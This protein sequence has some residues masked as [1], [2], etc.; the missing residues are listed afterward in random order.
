M[1]NAS[2]HRSLEKHVNIL[3]VAFEFPPLAS[4]GVQRS[5]KFVKYLPDFGINPVVI[6]IEEKDYPLVLSSYYIDKDLQQDV[7]SGT[8]IERIHCDA[9]SPASNKL[10]K[11]ARVYFSVSENFKTYW[12]KSLKEKLPAIIEE[13][14][15]LAVY[16]TIPPFAMAPLW[17]K[18]LKGSSLP[19]IIDFRDA[20]SQWALAPNGSYLHYY[21]KLKQEE[22]ILRKAAAVITTT[23]QTSDELK[24]LHHNIPADKFSVIPNGYD[25]EI[26]VPGKLS[27][28]KKDKWVIGYVGSFY[29]SPEAR[30]AIFKPWWKK[31]FHRMLQYVPR[32]EDWLYRS[33]YFFFKALKCLLDQHP[34]LAEKIEVHFAGNTP[35]WLTDQI[36]SFGLH[37]ICKHS[38]YLS[39]KAVI[40]FQQQCDALLI[41][42]SKVI[43]GEDYSI[44]GKTFEYFTMGKP[45]LAFVCEG[46]QKDILTETGMSVIC[47]PDNT[48]GSAQLMENLFTG[49]TVLQPDHAAIK[50]YHRKQLAQQLSSIIKKLAKDETA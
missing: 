1:N 5:L 42:S 39:H 45:I 33:P 46:A 8:K 2:E 19:L 38:G 4:G 17:L 22:A 23:R 27:V 10:A 31:K 34:A 48:V 28:A 43:G 35:G 44:A 29:Y 21:F 7:P 25:V 26:A 6:T 30:A 18:L 32:K 41:T 20:W 12:Y 50:K 47:D 49:K 37:S 9:P 3:F 15:P 13:Y 16:V 40:E 14:K 24:R 11:W 36:S